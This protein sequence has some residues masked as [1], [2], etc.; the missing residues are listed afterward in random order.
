M[1]SA[2]WVQKRNFKCGTYLFQRFLL[3]SE[4]S[5]LLLQGRHL[6]LQLSPGLL[7]TF[8]FGLS[9]LRG[10]PEFWD[11]TAERL[12]AEPELH[13]CRFP[14]HALWPLHA[15][16]CDH[17]R[18]VPAL[19]S[20][21]PR[22]PE[23]GGS[24]PNQPH[25]QP[26]FVSVCVSPSPHTEW[27]RNASNHPK[28]PLKRITPQSHFSHHLDTLNR[29]SLSISP[30]PVSLAWWDTPSLLG[31]WDILPRV[32]FSNTKKCPNKATG[33]FLKKVM[34]QNELGMENFWG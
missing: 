19:P 21:P 12:A 14:H 15:T 4:I 20:A 28:P 32:S 23:K 27:K 2:S 8:E 17:M 6:E 33:I 30:G 9:L 26:T 29:S 22:W 1:L 34:H 3:S 11:R 18:A 16:T 5:Q 7:F 25:H 13:S 31:S 24:G 10:L